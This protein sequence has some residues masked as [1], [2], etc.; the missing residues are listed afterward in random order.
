RVQI[1]DDV[2]EF[3]GDIDI[4]S[5]EEFIFEFDYDE[6]S[7]G[8]TVTLTEEYLDQLLVEAGTGVGDITVSLT[9]DSWDD[10]DLHMT[11]PD[12]S[13]IYYGNK[14]GG[15]GILDH[16]A[17]AGSERTITPIENI[18]FAAP[19]NG[20]YSIYL[21]EFNDRTEEGPT[22]YL[23]RVTI[24]GETQVFTGTIDTTG[25]E[26]PILDFDYSGSIGMGQTSYTGHTYSYIS[27][28][29]SW[30]DA[31]TFAASLGGH[32]VTISDEAE[33][34]FIQQSF[35][36][37]YG[38][39]G[40]VGY[41]SDYAWETGEPVSYT[42]ICASQPNN[43]ASNSAYGFLYTGQ[44]WAFTE[45]TDV[46]YH[47]GF[48]IEWDYVVEGAVDGI[49][50]ESTLDSILN[51]VN[52]GSGDIT[53]SMLWDSEDDLDLHIFTPDGSEIY[54]GN[55][56]AGGG[57]L[58]VDANTSTT[59]M[60]NPVENIYFPDPVNGEYWV[61]V[62]DYDDRSDGP[63]NFIVRITV[64]G[65]SQT[66]SG[67]IETSG[68]TIEVGGFQ[69]TGGTDMP[70]LDDVLNSL[71]AGTGEITISMMW[72]NTDDL[73]LHVI[74]PDGSHLYYGNRSA[75]GGELDI[76]ANTASN[77]M[78]N[79]VENIFFET[80][81]A[82]TY[83]V[84]IKNYSDRSDGSSANYVVRVTV[85]GESQTF[86]GTIDGS[87]T[88]IDIITFEYGGAGTSGV[89]PDGTDDAELDAILDSVGALSGDITISLFWNTEDDL[90]LHVS[91][92]AGS[93]IYYGNR[94][95]DGGHLDID[96]NT[97]SNMMDN[98]VEN[99]YFESPASGTYTVWIKDYSDR[100]DG[101]TSY[102]VR[103]T[104]GDQS[105]TYTGTI[106]GSTSRV[107]IV[108]FNYG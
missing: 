86:T 58:D 47:Y 84:Y 54:Y 76:D 28:Q 32:L 82:G 8:Q 93:E 102:T 14:S 99:I 59:M 1:G 90:D 103:V 73:D 12:G 19:Q 36:E 104:V 27:S 24:G 41:G 89:T 74:T 40:L 33:Q 20:S 85:G 61:Y 100:S 3:E 15:G 7:S 57:I 94:D 83:R 5:T 107:D 44:Q 10:V 51:S 98:P 21:K 56:Q 45:N 4:T 105:Q 78:D 97:S 49:L 17:N 35:P 62:N 23:L 50:S 6:G 75:Q 30:S 38:W 9:W 69:Y 53:V 31:R 18:Y 46:E 95:A 34:M 80:P 42:N 87:G 108:S 22:N 79:P 55:R 81:E 96:A 52:A 91:T 88:E 71:E 26:I 68:T 29:M 48:Y 2:Q 11:T 13:H 37:T 101:V 77:M 60:D 63:T 106:D 65:E 92:P 39:I 72:D 70:N 67:T 16:D 64:G 25:T 43:Y 66:F